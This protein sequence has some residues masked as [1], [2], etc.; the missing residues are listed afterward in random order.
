MREGNRENAAVTCPFF[1]Q[2]KDKMI[3]CERMKGGQSIAM[4]F[5]GNE[6]K[7]MYSLMHCEQDPSRCRLHNMLMDYY[8]EGS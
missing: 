3:V 8:G 7:D 2:A 4:V 1:S 6:L 5:R